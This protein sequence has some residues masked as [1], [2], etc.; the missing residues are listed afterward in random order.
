MPQPT[1]NWQFSSSIAWTFYRSIWISPAQTTNVVDPPGLSEPEGL[2][3]GDDGGC[4]AAAAG[5]PRGQ[6]FLSDCS[7]DDDG[8][9]SLASRGRA[10]QVND[11]A[12][13]QRHPRRQKRLKMTN[14]WKQSS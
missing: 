1:K 6:A 13:T 3:F 4:A 11:P 9:V 12:R 5:F 2:S 7:V 14:G 8:F 10:S